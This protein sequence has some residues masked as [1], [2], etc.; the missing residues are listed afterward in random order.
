MGFEPVSPCEIMLCIGVRAVAGIIRGKA[1]GFIVKER[2][3]VEIEDLFA[4]L[5]AGDDKG[6]KVINEYTDYR[7]YLDYDIDIIKKNGKRQNV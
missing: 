2:I 1:A 3:C 7:S 4:K 6:E 5:M